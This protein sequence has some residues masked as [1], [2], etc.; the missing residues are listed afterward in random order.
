MKNPHDHKNTSRLTTNICDSDSFNISSFNIHI[1]KVYC[2]C[3]SRRQHVFV[4]FFCVGLEWPWAGDVRFLVASANVTV[5]VHGR[6]VSSSA[7]DIRPFAFLR[8]SS[9]CRRFKFDAERLQKISCL[10]PR[11]RSV[12]LSAVLVT[13]G[14]VP[15]HV[16]SYMAWLL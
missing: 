12:C 7:R 4:Y 15:E 10:Y 1:S 5:W 11:G 2:E 6:M 8:S 9:G 13:Q 3:V 14:P 16:P